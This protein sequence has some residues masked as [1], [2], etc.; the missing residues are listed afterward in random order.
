MADNSL[1]SLLAWMKED[2]RLL[3]W[4]LVVAFDRRKAN[5]LIIQEY[6]QRFSTGSYFRVTGE[7]PIVENQHMEYIHDFEL[8]VPRLSFGSADLNDSKA[9]LTMAIMGGR[10][11]S[12][13]KEGGS[14]KAD[15]VEGIDPLQGPRLY[16]DLLL[17][18][19]PGDVEADGRVMLDLSK[20][21][22]FHLTFSQTAHAQRLGGSYFKD[23]FKALP[24][25]E[26]TYTLGRI[27]PGANKL[28]RPQ[29][30]E[31][32]TQARKASATD[33]E[34]AILALV[35]MMARNGG[36][37]PGGGYKYLIPDDTNKDYSATVLFDHNRLAASVLIAEVANFFEISQADDF[38][39]LFDD[40]GEFLSAA[41]KSGVLH[42]PAVDEVVVV[43]FSDMMIEVDLKIDPFQFLAAHPNVFTVE[44][45]AGKLWIRWT[46]SVESQSHLSVLSPGWGAPDISPTLHA[47]IE[48]SAEYEVVEGAGGEVSLRQMS[49]ECKG[50]ARFVDLSPVEVGEGWSSFII[51]YIT[52]RVEKNYLVEG[53]GG[54]LKDAFKAAFSSDMLIRDFI[55][56][57]IK[58]NFGQAIQGNEVYAP[59]DIGFFGRINPTHTSFAIKQMEPLLLHGEEFTFTTEPSVPGVKWSVDNL[60]TSTSLPGTINPDTGKYVAPEATMFEGRYTRVR[61]TARAPS[62]GY[63]SSALVTVVAN[64]LTVN[65]LIQTCKIGATVE[66]SAGHLDAGTLKWEIKNPVPGESGTVRPSEKPEGDHTYH[67]GGPVEE[68]TYVLDEIEVGTPTGEKRSVHVLALM[69]EPGLTVNIVNMD[70]AKGEVQLEAIVNKK[71]MPA[72]WSLPLKGPGSIDASGLYRTAPTATDQFV[73]IFAVVDG[74]PFGKFE[75]YLILPLPLVKFPTLLELLSQK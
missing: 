48:L 67:H 47:T 39:Y 23:L 4:G 56:Q 34:G 43:W 8:D 62:G 54:R 9:V 3:N 55:E 38:N 28:M 45:D 68:K 72:Q 27:Q 12:L 37:Y 25:E 74:G 75:G 52:D 5:L 44:L 1:S 15:R 46:T 33:Q 73:L 50:A 18:Q 60:V 10:Q 19:V 69:Q 6:I 61:V 36:N 29:S 17:N 71:V 63:S 14:W 66:L 31:L 70:I 21:D 51:S 13:K 32:R 58:L 30:F 49:I 40:S 35:R 24:A 16:L 64:K 7:V 26:R 11:F 57:T 20:S 41:S 53:V 22:N 65:P 59:T 2:T 42:V